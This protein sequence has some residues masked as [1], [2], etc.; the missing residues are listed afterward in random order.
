M[1]HY[2]CA[3]TIIGSRWVITS[4]HCL[5]DISWWSTA[6]HIGSNNPESDGYTKE[7]KNCIIHKDYD[8]NT[9]AN[10]VAVI[11]LKSEIEWI[12]PTHPIELVNQEFEIIDE[13]F[14]RTAGFGETCEGCGTSSQLYELVQTTCTPLTFL[15]TNLKNF[16]DEGKETVMC[17]HDVNK[18]STGLY[19]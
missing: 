10:D 8:E 4:T 17:S 5:L 14:V 11:E 12:Y 2:T 6:Y 13:L 16:D 15:G 19:I 3:G 18:K 1:Y 7:I 9:Y